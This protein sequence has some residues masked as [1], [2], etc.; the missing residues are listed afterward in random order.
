MNLIDEKTGN[1][2]EI[3]AG[4]SLHKII[5]TL[6]SLTNNLPHF[7]K[8]LDDA[9]FR[10]LITVPHNH[11]FTER[12]R[13]RN[14]VEKLLQEKD[15]I[16]SLLIDEVK[17]YRE[18]GLVSLPE[19][20]KSGQA[21]LISGDAMITFIQEQYEKTDGSCR[22][23]RIPMR[24]IEG[25]YISWCRAAMIDCYTVMKP[26]GIAARGYTVSVERLSNGEVKKM[27]KAFR[28]MGFTIKTYD[29]SPY[30]WCEFRSGA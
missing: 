17:K 23:L 4:S 7:D 8:D 14:M 18:E 11:V 22:N 3:Y 5:C 6:V 12:E 9:M 13:D 16:F 10:R 2:R 27:H 20:W 30:V 1:L 25:R 15:A 24:I 26:G 29:G 21:Q 19:H 28:A